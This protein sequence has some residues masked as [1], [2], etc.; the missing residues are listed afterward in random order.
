[1]S[2]RSGRI[3]YLR[4]LND[5]RHRPRP[6]MPGSTLYADWLL[7]PPRTPRILFDA[8]PN[9]LSKSSQRVRQEGSV[10]VMRVGRRPWT[11]HQHG[12]PCMGKFSPK[13]SAN[14]AVRPTSNSNSRLLQDA[15]P[16]AHRVNQGNRSSTQF[17]PLPTPAGGGE[18]HQR[19]SISHQGKRTRLWRTVYVRI[20]P[21][22]SHT[23]AIL[24]P[25]G[26]TQGGFPSIIV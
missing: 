6:A 25:D 1:V 8:I 20:S 2:N 10:A 17:Y 11:F 23:N 14:Q 7:S 15:H 21:D 24:G 12:A 13:K 22:R 26:L 5:G 3:L 4:L 16:H 9:L 18:V 19:L